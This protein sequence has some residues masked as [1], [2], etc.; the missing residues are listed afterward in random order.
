MAKPVALITNFR[1][2]AFPRILGQIAAG[3]RPPVADWYV[4]TYGISKEMAEKITAKGFLYAPVCAIQPHT[5]RKIRKKRQLRKTEEALLRPDFAGEIPASASAP[6][7]PPAKRRAWGIEFGQRYRDYMRRQRDAGVQI[8]AWQF[9]E[10]VG[11][12]ASIVGYREFVGGILRG[13][14]EG[15][16]ELDDELERGFVWFSFEA[17]SELRDP[18]FSA[19]VAGFW[20]E[21][22]RAT[23]F[24]V[25][26]E[27]PF[28]RGSPTAAARDKGKGHTR[29]DGSLGQLR[30]KYICVMTPGWKS[31]SSLGGNVD[32]Q[33]PAF[34]T[35]W[36]KDFIDARIALQRPRGYGQFSFT[37]GNV[38]PPER[39]DD[40]VE[41]LHFAS[42]R[43]ASS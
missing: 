26:E 3:P 12:C 32:G 10:I 39:I 41:S 28:F 1:K 16:A 11:K 27:Y 18:T 4:G 22:A 20:E 30:R 40:A 33:P 14:S 2:D 25:G 7:I 37:H 6:I 31:S 23:L 36:R 21:V 42:K 24:L 38:S 34:V 13:L 17:L 9:D 5:S 43:L 29:L 35:N 8:D 15:R 19:E